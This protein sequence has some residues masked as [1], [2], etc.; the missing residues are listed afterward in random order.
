[1]SNPDSGMRV[2]PSLDMTSFM[3]YIN[4]QVKDKSQIDAI[5]ELLKEDNLDFKTE[6]PNS[7]YTKWAV[8]SKVWAESVARVLNYDD[9]YRMENVNGF[10]KK[11]HHPEFDE[12]EDLVNF[13]VYQA[14]LKMTS[15]KGRRVQAVVNALKGADPLAN[16]YGGENKVR[17]SFLGLGR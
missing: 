8:K 10:I 12:K 6:W 3:D 4:K 13:M 5:L 2:N 17:R 16:I 15:H 14:M 9:G 7:K 1:M 11:V